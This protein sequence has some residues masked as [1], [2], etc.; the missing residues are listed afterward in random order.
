MFFFSP[1]LVFLVA[2]KTGQGRK[3]GGLLLIAGAF[4]AS[5]ARSLFKKMWGVDR[6]TCSKAGMG[7]GNKLGSRGRTITKSSA[8]F[9]CKLLYSS[10]GGTSGQ[11]CFYPPIYAHT[12]ENSTPNLAQAYIKNSSTE[13][14]GKNRL[15]EFAPSAAVKNIITTSDFLAKKRC[16]REGCCTFK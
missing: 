4:Y 13:N 9:P 15:L 7:K 8:E 12:K 10:F 5:R 11:K 2:R 3:G 16:Q 1:F 14:Q 6:E